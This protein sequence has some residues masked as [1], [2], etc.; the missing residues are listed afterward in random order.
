MHLGVS[1]IVRRLLGARKQI[2]LKGAK[3]QRQQ[4][5]STSC[6]VAI[7]DGGT[8]QLGTSAEARVVGFSSRARRR[9]AEFQRCQNNQQGSCVSRSERILSGKGAAATEAN[10]ANLLP[11]LGSQGSSCIQAPRAQR[12]VCE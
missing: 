7:G 8:L 6:R 10:S 12:L 11:D 5:S 1:I 9:E 2:K 4:L 3:K